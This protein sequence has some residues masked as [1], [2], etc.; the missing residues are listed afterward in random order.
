MRDPFW[1]VL[2]S[3]AKQACNSAVKGVCRRDE[4]AKNDPFWGWMASAAKNLAC[5]AVVSFL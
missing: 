4:L 2:G 3:A 1:N 5:K